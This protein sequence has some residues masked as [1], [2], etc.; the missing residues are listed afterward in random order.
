[1]AENPAFGL[2]FGHDLA[3]AFLR[4]YNPEMAEDFTARSPHSIVVSAIG[5]MGAVGLVALGALIA[6]FAARTWQAV[7]HPATPRVTL[8]LWA[9]V[10]TIL[11]SACFGVVLEGPMGAVVFWSLLGILS[12]SGQE[13]KLAPTGGRGGT[14]KSTTSAVAS[15]P[16]VAG[17]DE[18]SA[19]RIP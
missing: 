5:R 19:I 14:E 11:I 6:L 1:M 7:R 16:A 13:A 17:A 10:W 2:G 15:L 3:R 8:G 18:V 9:C 12:S 4:E